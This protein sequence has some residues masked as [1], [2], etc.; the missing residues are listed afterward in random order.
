ME[1]I[2]EINQ[3]LALRGLVLVRTKDGV[4]HC[5]FVREDW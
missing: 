3:A 4:D 2:D 5:V 1:L